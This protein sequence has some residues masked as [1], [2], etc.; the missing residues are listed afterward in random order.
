MNNLTAYARWNIIEYPITYEMNGHGIE[1]SRKTYTVEDEYTPPTQSE[2]GWTFNGWTPQKIERGSTGNKTFTAYWNIINYRITYEM[3]GHGTNPSTNP[4]SYNVE[5]STII[6]VNP[7]NV[8]GYNFSG[9]NPTSIPSGSTGNKTFT[10]NWKQIVYNLTVKISSFPNGKPLD[11]TIGGVYKGSISDNVYEF[12]VAENEEIFLT[13]GELSDSINIKDS[14]GNAWDVETSKTFKMPNH[15]YELNIFVSQAIGTNFQCKSKGGT[16][17]FEGVLQGLEEGYE[18]KVEVPICM[19]GHYGSSK[20]HK[21]QCRLGYESSDGTTHY[22]Y[23]EVITNEETQEV[24]KNTI[25]HTSSTEYITTVTKLNGAG[26]YSADGPSGSDKHWNGSQN[27]DGTWKSDEVI[28][29]TDGLLGKYD[30]SNDYYTYNNNTKVA[31]YFAD[32]TNDPNNCVTGPK[33]H[34]ETFTIKPS[35]NGRC[36]LGISVKDNGGSGSCTGVGAFVKMIVTR[37]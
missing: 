34:N 6:P 17:V 35:G 16:Q 7:D 37:L 21:M 14:D 25:E 28:V 36:T 3:N 1:P 4:T 23:N 30:V 29:S 15:D 33:L 20:T 11:L 9:W 22:F 12:T 26:G 19:I 5:S 2:T 8:P 18:Y 10:A 27:S 31:F 24:T 32:P 13:S